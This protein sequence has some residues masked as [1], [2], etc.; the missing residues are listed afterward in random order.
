MA[1][2]NT[3]M[4]ML[5]GSDVMVAMSDSMS[6]TMSVTYSEVRASAGEETWKLYSQEE[7]FIRVMMATDMVNIKSSFTNL[8][9]IVDQ[10]WFSSFLAG[11]HTYTLWRG[12]SLTHRYTNTALIEFIAPLQHFPITQPQCLFYI[13]KL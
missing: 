9:E 3:S 2:N 11:A 6:D 1:G 8:S 4:Q 7:Q 10:Q 12:K 13:S 5:M